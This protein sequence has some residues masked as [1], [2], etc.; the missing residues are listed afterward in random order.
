MIV[1]AAALVA[2]LP[3]S[4]LRGRIEFAGLAVPGA[5][6][7]A[8]RADRVA[9]TT[10]AE[11]GSFRIANLP[12]GAW[13][14]LVEM[15][16]FVTVV[17][18]ISLPLT[19]SELAV[20]LTMKPYADVLTSLAVVAS[21]PEAPVVAATSGADVDA[22]ILLGTVTNGAATPFAQ[23]R[24]AGNARPDQ[25]GQYDGSVSTTVANSAW[26]AR[27]YSFGGASA[28]ADT[29]DLQLGFTLTG[30]L[31]L[32]W[33][34]TNGPRMTISLQRGV[35]SSATTQSARVPTL[36]ERAGDFSASS[37]VVRDPD[38]GIP[39]D[40]NVVPS[41]RIAP[42]A[43]ALLAYYPVPNLG[44]AEGANYERPIVTTTSQHGG[45]FQTSLTLPK[46]N[47]VGWDLAARRTTTTG[48]NLFDFANRRAQSTVDAGVTWTRTISARLQVTSRYPVHA[49]GRHA[50]AA[51]RRTDQRLR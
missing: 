5:S 1:A 27:P 4:D 17:R 37:V 23:P 32:P 40:R 10:S 41:A 21:P 18:E 19:E 43:G 51:L 25:P 30:P 3:P 46:R 14:V 49:A 50:D 11:D 13:Q 12:D 33:I 8:T 42:Q 34:L 7:T 39:F 31:R 48:N 29:G 16:G 26:N 24:A 38:T 6:I 44:A 28:T 47:Q 45:R 20:S 22:V 9:A 15:R 36:A 2:P 35:S